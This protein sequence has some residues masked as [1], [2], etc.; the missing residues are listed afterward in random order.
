M[1]GEKEFDLNVMQCL[2]EETE[3]TKRILAF[4]EDS[5]SDD[6][7]M[8]I[9]SSLTERIDMLE[10]K[11][12]ERS[13]DPSVELSR[14]IKAISNLENRNTMSKV[15]RYSLFPIRDE[16]AYY[17]YK[18]HS[19]LDWTADELEFI[20]DK[21]D[22]DESS[23]EEQSLMDKV[24]TFFLIGDGAISENI[25]FRLLIEA[26]TYE[27]K[28]YFI[29]QLRRELTHAET[30]GLSAITF[31]PEEDKLLKLQNE[32]NDSKYVKAKIDFIEKYMYC[33]EPLG[34]RFAAFTCAEGIFFSVL[35]FVIFWWRSRNKFENFTF[36]NEL[37]SHDEGLHAL[38]NSI[39]CV[40]YGGCPLERVQ[41]I[42]KEA[43]AIEMMFIEYLLPEPILELT[44]DMM[45]DYCHY[46]ADRMLVMLGSPKLYL[47]PK[48]PSWM[49]DISRTQKSNFYER[50]VG[51]YNKASL[52][53]VTNIKKRTTVSDIDPIKNPELIQ[54]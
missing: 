45:R 19:V 10:K 30:Y 44:A 48:P 27:E 54:Y 16:E 37:I 18:E 43:V 5:D 50:R 25:V 20:K 7:A 34:H 42:V 39:L 14:L 40:K 9:I 46:V 36:A 23:P 41:Q 21:K 17:M 4:D 51:A 26:K 22:Y 13:E 53:E 49:E 47:G 1:Q 6:C 11:L 28:A 31:I 24:N 32:A 2:S 38:N 35:F 12:S 15:Q 3:L 8:G 29:D 52:R 33:E